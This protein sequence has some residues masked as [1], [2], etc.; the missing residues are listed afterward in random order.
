MKIDRKSYM[1]RKKAAFHESLFNEFLEV[2]KSPGKSTKDKPKSF[3]YWD[4]NSDVM[5]DKLKNN[6]P[7]DI[8]Q[9]ND[10]AA[11]TIPTRRKMKNTS[12][13]INDP[14]KGVEDI[15]VRFRV[16]ERSISSSQI[17]T[18]FMARLKANTYNIEQWETKKEYSHPLIKSRAHSF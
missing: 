3:F 9:C 2:D 7:L 13:T 5:A 17:D 12:P 18:S 4:N 16:L 15:N 10:N 14:S 11:N 1:L 8:S 6:L